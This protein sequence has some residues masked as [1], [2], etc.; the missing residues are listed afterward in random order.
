MKTS[1]KVTFDPNWQETYGDVIRS[2]EKA[3]A[4]V[5]SGHRVFVGTGCA[6]P[7]RLVRALVARAGE[8]ED[9]EIIHLLTFGEAP[10]ATLEMAKTFRVNSFFIGANVR[11]VI[12]EGVG[13][14]TP[15]FLSDIPRLFDSGQIP[16]DVAFIQVSPPDQNGLCSYG[17]SVDIVKAAA[18]NASLV[19]AQ[20]NPKMPRT[21][22]NSTI[23]VH[24][25]D[26][27]VPVD[28]D[29]IE[30]DP[31]T[32]T[33]ATHRIGEF[34]AGLVDDGSTIEVGIGRI[35]QAIIQQLAD[36]RDLGIHTEMFS[37]SMI[38]IVES[39]V[40]TGR[41]KALDRN[42]V[43]ASFCVG[44]QRLYDYVHD[45]PVFAFHP[46]EYVND[47]F[48]IGRQTKPVAINTALEIDLTGQ[49]GADSLAGE[50]YSGIGGQVDFNRG[51]ARA[52]DGKAIIAMPSTAKDDSV[53]RIV[54]RLSAGAGVVTTRGDVHYVVTEYGVAYLHGKSVEERAISLISIAHPDF[55]EQLLKEAID[56]RF[57]HPEFARVEG[58]LVVGPAD[59]R[60]SRIL[61]DGTQV[62]FRPI[63]PTD[64]PALV[65]LIYALSQETMYYRF[66]SRSKRV[67]RREIQNFVFIDHRSELAIVCTVPEA[68]GEDIIAVGRYYLDEKS[69]MA[70]VAFVVRDDWQNRGIGTE[71]LRYLTQVAMRNGI[72]GFT[73]EVLRD[74]RAMQRVLHKT[75]YKVT[76]EPHE[77][78]Y[79]FVIEFQPSAD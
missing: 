67:P 53:S 6:Q 18:E 19:I 74:N 72:R 34:V 38:D 23:H 70:E 71:L 29:L 27:L 48:V 47:P 54:T 17:I 32:P 25:I 8:L 66:M 14:Y 12:Q 73:A 33:E 28:D 65:D 16:L 4:K 30:Y 44:S 11:E 10:Y 40:V 37:D 42:R 36:K 5:R 59:L 77:D 26:V 68:H 41:H 78:V 46:T 21:H 31:P 64:E 50:F 39:G 79:S 62:T 63:H 45:N 35:P 3:V 56:A 9:I 43:V 58:K 49:V 7:L 76:S 2:A 57:L 75:N 13:A 20:V 61:N 52:H 1:R 15:V 60:T 69:N 22:G 55:R 24:E 51:A